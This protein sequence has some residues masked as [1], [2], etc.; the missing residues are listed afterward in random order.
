MLILLEK[1]SERGKNLDL[2]SNFS[3][4]ISQGIC[5][6]DLSPMQNLEGVDI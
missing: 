3:L 5:F 2:K 6:F 1:K 4:E